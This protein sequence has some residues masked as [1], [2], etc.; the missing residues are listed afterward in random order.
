MQQAL[1]VA[2]VTGTFMPP[3]RLD[4]LKT[5]PHP[6]HNHL[7]CMDPDC[8]ELNCQGNRLNLVRAPSGPSG[9]GGVTWPYFDYANTRLEFCI[10]HGKQD[11]RAI[12][13]A[14]RVRFVVPHGDL[15]KLL[16]AHIVRG[17][18]LLTLEQEEPS[19]R[20]FVTDGGNSFCNSTFV[21]YWEKAMKTA[22]E[23]GIKYFP[24]SKG[25]CICLCLCLCLSLY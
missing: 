22:Q 17:R 18:A 14:Y 24:P 21:Q 4:L 9:P 2:L 3:V 23:F 15:L 10:V 5:L 13:D 25:M 8:I 16:L 12:R 1:I 11:R 20:L 6:Q 19:M 7:G